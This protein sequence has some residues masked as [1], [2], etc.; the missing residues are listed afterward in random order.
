MAVLPELLAAAVKTK[1]T[2]V[3]Q[4]SYRWFVLSLL[5]SEKLLR[6]AKS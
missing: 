6:G 4:R 1:L 2:I 3:H 5:G